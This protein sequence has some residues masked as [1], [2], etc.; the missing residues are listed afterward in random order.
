M[1]NANIQLLMDK[2]LFQ[3]TGGEF[4]TLISCQNL[5]NVQTNSDSRVLAYGVQEL[6]DHLGCSQSAVFGLKRQ[7]VLDGAIVPNVGKKI[8][9]D[10]EKARVLIKKYLTKSKK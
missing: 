4:I 9:F 6:C 2:P 5:G 8:V 1:E 10:V 7:G 3:M